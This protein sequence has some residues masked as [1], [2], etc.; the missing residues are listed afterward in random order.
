L[1]LRGT[2]PRAAATQSNWIAPALHAYPMRKYLLLL[3]V[4]I[5]YALH[6]DVWNWKKVDPL[7]FGFIPIGLA[8]HAVYSCVA[9]VVMW[10]L[11]RFAW[12]AHLEKTETHRAPDRKEAGE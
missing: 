3:L 10:L 12:P 6:Q 9:A 11:V 2:A 1:P 7:I 5:V 8:Y 4:I